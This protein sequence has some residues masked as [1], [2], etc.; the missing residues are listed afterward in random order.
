MILGRLNAICTISAFSLE[1]L[2]TCIAMNDR[3]Q[4]LKKPT[5]FIPYWGD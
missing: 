4:L 5:K 3:G 2:G 1:V